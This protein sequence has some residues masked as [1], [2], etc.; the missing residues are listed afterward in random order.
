MFNK[1]FYPTP[2]EVIENMLYG[3]NLDGKVILE[4]QAGKGNIVR[5]I[6][7]NYKPKQILACE[8]EP[9]LR[10]VL[11]GHC[12]LIGEDFLELTADKISHIDY[13][14]MNPPF[15][16]DEKHVL[17]AFEIA[18]D[19]C[20]IISLCAG[21]VL[22]YGRS[23]QLKRRIEALVRTYGY[24]ENLGNCF[25]TAERKTDVEVIKIV[26]QKPS[27][28][29]EDIFED[30]FDL[31]D[32]YEDSNEDGLMSYNVVRDVVNRHTATLKL[33]EQ[34]LQI[35]TQINYLTAE[36]YH[37]GKA[38]FS[39]SN[40][41]ADLTRN[42]FT[43]ELTKQSWLGVLK[44]MNFQQTLTSSL[45][46]DINKF[47][48]KQ[49]KIPFTM[50]N[51]YKMIDLIIGTHK[52]RMDK[53]IIDVFYKL[54]DLSKDNINAQ[55]GWVSNKVY[56][57][58]KKIIVPYAIEMGYDGCPKVRITYGMGI[59]ILEDFY[60]AYCHIVG[61]TYVESNKL[62][63]FLQQNKQRYG[64]LF[65]WDDFQC[66]AYKKGTLHIILPEDKQA[67]INQKIASI[68]GFVIPTQT[69]GKKRKRKAKEV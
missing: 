55:E 7:A 48:E 53:A 64:E 39:V 36:H 52:S 8:I 45:R 49:E 26:L 41:N 24:S 51:V 54:C 22:H 47:V 40:K 11:S 18:P 16:A 68:V 6:K 61:K 14:I 23:S 30:Y 35:A 43:K 38:C 63:T 29:Q 25:S 37:I 44:I 1:D 13:I 3:Y 59:D 62:Y 27:S 10:K 57:I 33:Y 34:Q 20:K 4:P 46:N 21:T 15:S 60:K 67:L 32:D 12:N 50:R 9:D 65:D 69:S 66:R 58:N 31:D 5:Y 28:N 42:E 17:H 2:D 56:M 19:G